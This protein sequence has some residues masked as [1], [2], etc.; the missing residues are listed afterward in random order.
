MIAKY[1]YAQDQKITEEIKVLLLKGK[2]WFLPNSQETQSK[3]S[4]LTFPKIPLEYK[5]FNQEEETKPRWEC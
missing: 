5:D 3:W 1:Q 2:T 4:F